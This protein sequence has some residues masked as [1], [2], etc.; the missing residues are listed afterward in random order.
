ML[1]QDVDVHYFTGAPNIG[2]GIQDLVWHPTIREGLQRKNCCSFGFCPNERG[3]GPAQIFW[4]RFISE[5]LVNKRSFF[6]NANNLNFNLFFRLSRGFRICMAKGVCTSRF[7]N[8]A[9]G[10]WSNR[11]SKNSSEIRKVTWSVIWLWKL[12]FMILI[13]FNPL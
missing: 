6:Q 10:R 9:K 1:G 5:F 8:F 2:L 7:V 11:D 12:Q 13:F 3:V 4:H